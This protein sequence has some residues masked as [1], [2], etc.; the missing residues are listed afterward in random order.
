MIKDLKKNK[1]CF[2]KIDEA[3]N[4]VNKNYDDIISWWEKNHVQKSREKFCE[5]YCRRFYKNKNVLKKL[6]E[7]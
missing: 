6:F 5:K 2:E 7:N 4:F 3:T 1:I